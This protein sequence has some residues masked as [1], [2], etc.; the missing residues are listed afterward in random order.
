[1][2]QS[3]RGAWNDTLS[4][5]RQIN[6]RAYKNRTFDPNSVPELSIPTLTAPGE[7]AFANTD[8][9]TQKAKYDYRAFYFLT[10]NVTRQ[11][12]ALIADMHKEQ[13]LIAGG[14]EKSAE[15]QEFLKDSP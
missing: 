4:T 7:Q 13:D 1:M 3:E 8:E 12:D 5:L 11:T 15:G 9:D 10:R 6:E 2:L 14:L